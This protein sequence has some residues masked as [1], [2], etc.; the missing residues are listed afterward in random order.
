MF[1]NWDALDK[2]LLGGLISSFLVTQCFIIYHS[3][4]TLKPK[5]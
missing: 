4:S 3:P 5:K 2:R 1:V